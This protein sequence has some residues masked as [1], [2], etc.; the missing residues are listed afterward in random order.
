MAQRCLGSASAPGLREPGALA[1]R[2]GKDK[3][4][5][6]TLENFFLFFFSPDG[7]P[8]T[9][10]MFSS[11]CQGPSWFK[12]YIAPVA[13]KSL[14]YKTHHEVKG[15]GPVCSQGQDW[16]ERKGEAP[17][18]TVAT[19]AGVQDEAGLMSEH[20]VSWVTLQHLERDLPQSRTL[21]G[22][23]EMAKKTT[24]PHENRPRS[25]VGHEPLI[26]SL[27]AE[28][29]VGMVQICIS[30]TRRVIGLLL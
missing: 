24:L 17:V 2:P 16:E 3:L 14:S 25:S 5:K 4:R 21:P 28:H 7:I 9:L 20:C 15:V 22:S 26:K 27:W 11:L 10:H 12:N 6:Y 30:N 1:S 23:Q 8:K 19:S 18:R 13:V 29:G